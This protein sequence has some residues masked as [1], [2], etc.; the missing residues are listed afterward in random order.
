M[1]FFSFLLLDRQDESKHG[2]ELMAQE[3]H[4][5]FSCFIAHYLSTN[6]YSPQI[7]CRFD[8]SNHIAFVMRLEIYI[9][10]V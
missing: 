5:H 6:R 7:T 10:Y 2:F 9:I 1:F 8:F 4:I 3:L